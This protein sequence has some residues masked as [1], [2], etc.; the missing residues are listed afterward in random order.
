MHAYRVVLQIITDIE[1][2]GEIWVRGPTVMKV[3]VSGA[4][5]F[6][7]VAHTGS[8]SGVL[9]QSQ[10][11]G[12]GD[13]ARRVVQDGGCCDQRRRGISHDHR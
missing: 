3:C 9:E 8:L 5:C 1:G 12:V 11:D 13:H 10:C 7:Q 2:A 4:V 6:L